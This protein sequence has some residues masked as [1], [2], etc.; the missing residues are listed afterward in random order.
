MVCGGFVSSRFFTP[1]VRSRL[2]IPFHC[3]CRSHSDIEL[4]VRRLPSRSVCASVYEL[5]YELP[6]VTINGPLSHDTDW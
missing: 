2:R 6:S 5:W 1:R 3:A 4:T